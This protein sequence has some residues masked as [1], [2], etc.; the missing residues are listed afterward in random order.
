MPFDANRAVKAAVW[1][2]IVWI[3]TLILFKIAALANLGTDGAFPMYSIALILG[4][5]LCLWAGFEVKEA[6]GEFG[7]AILAGIVVGLACGVPALLFDLGSFRF[8]ATIVIFSLA[9]SWAGWGLK[10]KVK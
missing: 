2:A 1:P 5:A 8:L 9:A 6:K 10:Q 4:F 7:E 3:I